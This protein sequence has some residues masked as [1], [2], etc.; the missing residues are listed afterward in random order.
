MAA[1]ARYEALTELTLS[2]AWFVEGTPSDGRTLGDFV[3]SCC[4]RL[5]NLELTSP[6]G[7]H[8]PLVLRAEALE[9]LLLFSAEGLTTLDVTAPKLRV[10]RVQLCSRSNGHGSSYIAYNY[11]INKVVTV[12]APS[13]QEIG[14][15]T[16][17]HYNRPAL[18]IQD[19][20][21]VRRLVDLYLD[22][23]GQYCRDTDVGLQLLESCPR[24]EH[25]SVLLDHFV[26]P[27]GHVNTSELVDL[28]SDGAAPFAMVKSVDMEAC[29]F[30]RH[31]LVTSISSFL[32]RSVGGRSAF[33]MT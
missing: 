12:M 9:E 15:Y 5:R 11:S 4:P 31:H 13:L 27:G 7:M 20:T 25:I 24:V 30:P 33:V 10:L 3:S 19:L 29:I 17:P 18:D 8:Q 14:V 1:A 2:K 26:S 16:T 22:M 32:S 23:H 6:W 28:A 21:G